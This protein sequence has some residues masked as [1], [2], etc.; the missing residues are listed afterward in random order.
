MTVYNATQVQ[1]Y[2]NKNIGFKIPYSIII[3][4]LGWLAGI[5][6]CVVGYIHHSALKKNNREREGLNQESAASA[7]TVEHIHQP[8]HMHHM[9]YGQAPY[10]QPTY[11]Q[12]PHGYTNVHAPP[13]NYSMPMYTK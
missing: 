7:H 9:A 8:P 2:K 3:A 10:G 4:G 1:K 5:G 6:G 13:E 12:P 11:G